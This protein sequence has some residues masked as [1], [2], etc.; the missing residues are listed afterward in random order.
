MITDGK[1]YLKC[2][3]SEGLLQNNKYTMIIL[4]ELQHCNQCQISSCTFLA[5]I[6]AKIRPDGH[7]GVLLWAGTGGGWRVRETRAARYLRSMTVL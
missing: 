7:L 2:L 5:K 6:A 3:C 1:I 4:T